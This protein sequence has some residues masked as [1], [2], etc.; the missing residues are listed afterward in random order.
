MERNHVPKR[1]GHGKAIIPLFLSALLSII[2]AALSA[3]MKKGMGQVFLSVMRERMNPGQMTF[4]SMPSGRSIPRR[5]M[6]HVLTH[7]FVAE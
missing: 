3:S 4:T 6:P 2:L 1:I 7:D 5:A